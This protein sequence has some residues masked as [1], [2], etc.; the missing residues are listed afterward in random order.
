VLNGTQGVRR[1]VVRI[2]DR[3]GGTAKIDLT[4]AVTLD[5]VLDAINSQSTANVKAS[6]QGDHLVITDLTGAATGTLTVKDLSG[7]YAA[8]DLGIAGSPR[9]PTDRPTFA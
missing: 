8:A 9:R 7:G 3:E 2:T 6:V 5:D 1:G 4:T